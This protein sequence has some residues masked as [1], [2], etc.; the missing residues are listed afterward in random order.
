M[1]NIPFMTNEEVL[2]YRP[3]SP[4]LGAPASK[5]QRCGGTNTDGSGGGGGGGSGGGGSGGGVPAVV[6]LEPLGW[7]H[8][9]DIGRISNDPA[10]MKWMAQGV[11]K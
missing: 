2:K 5:R 10:V 11:G 7:T 1:D 8:R 4:P 6:T 9:A 3:Q